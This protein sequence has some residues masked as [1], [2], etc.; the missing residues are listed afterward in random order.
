[1]SLLDRRREE[2]VCRERWHAEEGSSDERTA[3]TAVT[4]R[5]A[6]GG[7]RALGRCSR[8]AADEAEAAA[9]PFVCP[10][11]VCRALAAWRAARAVADALSARVRS[12]SMMEIDRGVIG[13]DQ[14]K[15]KKKKK[16][17]ES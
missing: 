16:K 4:G 17:A 10:H 5:A 1:M 3:A 2:E 9:A 11:S 13:S 6:R 15:K 14:R 8:A 7:G 12:V